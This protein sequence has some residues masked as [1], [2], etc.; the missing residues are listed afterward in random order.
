MAALFETL[1]GPFIEPVA[2]MR[3]YAEADH[4]WVEAVVL[5][6]FASVNS[7]RIFAYIPQILKAARDRHGAV[8]I[9]TATWG[10]FLASHLTTILYAVLVLGDAVMALVFFGNA[11]ACAAILGV[12]A[13]K[14]RAHRRR[15]ATQ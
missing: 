10:L 11:L 14:R 7:V 6:T 1:A 13:V 4:P 9:S 5:W 12:T 8:A 3:A 15:R 2:A